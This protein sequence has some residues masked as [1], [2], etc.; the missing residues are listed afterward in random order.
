MPTFSIGRLVKRAGVAVACP[1]LDA[2]N[3]EDAP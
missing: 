3:V 1:I 2:L